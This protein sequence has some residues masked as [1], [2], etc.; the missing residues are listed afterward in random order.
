LDRRA[1]HFIIKWNAKHL[2]NVDF[3]KGG[4]KDYENY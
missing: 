2:V 4:V 1:Q 3:P